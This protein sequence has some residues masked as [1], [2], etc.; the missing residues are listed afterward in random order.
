MD[1]WSASKR[2]PPA[3][4]IVLAA[5][6]GGMSPSRYKKKTCQRANELLASPWPPCKHEAIRHLHVSHNTPCLPPK[7]I[8]ENCLQFL[9]GTL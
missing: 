7:I 9:L 2:A 5:E 3:V 8:H 1:G 6:E 4:Y